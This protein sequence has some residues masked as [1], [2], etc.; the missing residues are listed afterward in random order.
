MPA[1]VFLIKFN[2]TVELKPMKKL[3][4]VFSLI[5]LSVLSAI[6]ANAQTTL[7]EANNQFAVDLYKK[8][9]R[10]DKNLFFSP[11]SINMALLTTYEGSSGKTKIAFEKVLHLNKPIQDDEKAMFVKSHIRGSDTSNVINFSNSLWINKDFK[12]RPEFQERANKI[13]L[14]EAN[15]LDVSQPQAMA[16]KINKWVLDRTNNR[17][18]NIIAPELIVPDTKLIILNTV[19]FKGEWEKEFSEMATLPR[20]F[21]LLDGTV[22]D[23]NSMS[24]RRNI[25]YF[26]NEDLQIIKLPYKGLKKSFC[27]I[28]P[29]RKDGLPDL[30][31]SLTAAG[32]DMLYANMKEE[33]VNCII[34]KFKL[35]N[36]FSLASPLRDMGLG[37]AFANSDFTAMSEDNG[38][39]INEIIHKTFFEISEKITEAAAAT[40][41]IVVVG[42][43]SVKKSSPAPK[44]KLFNA[45]HPFLFM[46]LDNDKN[47]ILFL[48]KYVKD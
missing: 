35:E 1:G 20:K 7:V 8:L 2:Q 13:Y 19:Y 40:E 47:E 21:Y 46:I 42:F 12:L 32:L 45:D 4:T 34:P 25:K 39:N 41:E 33:D 48:G 38:I 26:E 17:I 37:S 30:E 9:Q 43:G 24:G 23:I 31:R 3:A 11:A 16:L 10:P 18:K 15:S 29:K 14:A 22:K 5:L 44:P 27:V 28:L 36:E 6:R